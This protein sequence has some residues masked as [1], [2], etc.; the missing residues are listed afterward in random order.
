MEEKLEPNELIERLTQLV[1][2]QE[3]EKNLKNN[4]S[5]D[6]I[7]NQIK[8]ILNKAV[9]PNKHNKPKKIKKKKIKRQDLLK[10]ILEESAPDRGTNVTSAFQTKDENSQKFD[11]TNENF[12]V[13]LE[14]LGLF[15]DSH[16]FGFNFYSDSN[17]NPLLNNSSET[18]IKNDNSTKRDNEANDCDEDVPKD[19]FKYKSAKMFD[20]YVKN[21]K[22]GENDDDISYESVIKEDIDVLQYAKERNILPHTTP[23]PD[24]EVLKILGLPS[25]YNPFNDTSDTRD[26]KLS[27][28]KTTNT[29]RVK[30]SLLTLEEEKA[31]KKHRNKIASRKFRKTH[32]KKPKLD[33]VALAYSNNLKEIIKIMAPEIND[34]EMKV[35]SLME[36]NRQLSNDLKLK[37]INRLTT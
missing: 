16:R 18:E 21:F 8:D 12:N 19:F 27:F 11:Y 25:D 23:K 36:E 2:S 1:K 6:V 33:D 26:Q 15:D 5:S 17:V 32:S 14:D 22:L 29:F 7:I 35:K 4:N 10:E 34:L 31:L 28:D 37:Y 20:T 9:V 13:N 24:P 30:H 3:N